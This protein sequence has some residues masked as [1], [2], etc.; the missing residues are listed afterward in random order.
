MLNDNAGVQ[1][2]AQQKQKISCGPTGEKLASF[3]SSVRIHTVTALPINPSGARSIIH[4]S[5]A[6]LAPSSL[7]SR[8]NP[9]ESQNHYAIPLACGS[10]RVHSDFCFLILRCRLLLSLRR[11]RGRSL[12]L[13]IFS[14]ESLVSASQELVLVTSLPFVHTARCSH[15]WN[16]S[17]ENL[18]IDLFSFAEHVFRCLLNLTA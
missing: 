18:E 15:R 8:A 9:P 11:R 6:W 12:Q 3:S 5:N 14:E 10:L 4:N 2:W 17:V 16:G 7:L 13:S 1:R